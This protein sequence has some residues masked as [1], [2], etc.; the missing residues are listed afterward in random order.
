MS[1]MNAVFKFP[2][3][4]SICNNLTNTP[5]LGIIFCPPVFTVIEKQHIELVDLYL[6][7][8]WVLP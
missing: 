7:P 1:D 6:P 4:I 3:H 5:L 2:C 8:A